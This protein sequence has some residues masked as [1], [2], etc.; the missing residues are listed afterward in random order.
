MNILYYDILRNKKIGTGSTHIY[1]IIINLNKMGHNILFYDIKHSKFERSDLVKARPNFWGRLGTKIPFIVIILTF[2]E[3]LRILLSGIYQLKKNPYPYPNIL[4]YRHTLFNSGYWLAQLLGIPAIKEVNGL[5]ANEIN[6]ARTQ[7][8]LTL[9]IIDRIERANI[10]KANKIIVVT[11][12]LKE[13]LINQYKVPEERIEVIE[14]G[15]NTDMFRP[16]DMETVKRELNLDPDLSYICFVGN[17]AAWQGLES[18]IKCIP[19][20]LKAY[21]NTRFLLVG[22]G[23]LRRELSVMAQELGMSEMLIFTG[24]VPYWKV[25][26]Y[27][28]ASEVCVVYKRPMQSGY[29]PLKLY[30]YMACKKPVI[31]SKVEGFEILEKNNAGILVEPENPD[32]LAKAVIKLL[33]NDK[34]RD[35]MGRNGREYIVKNQSWECVASKIISVCLEVK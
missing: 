6:I 23:A 19:Q 24:M 31:A 16:M 34:L 1:E 12:N 3:E 14:N 27:V 15:A 30:E 35:E 21:P 11:P 4:Y 33:G 9:D 32:A 8:G 22:D 20:V 17:F 2:T 26:L 13:I 10:R 5:V 28:N 29:S 18:L 25:P 7:R